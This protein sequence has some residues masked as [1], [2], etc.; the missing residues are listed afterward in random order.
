VKVEIKL[1]AGLAQR[2]GKREMVLELQAG[3]TVADAEREL[4]S[5]IKGWPGNVAWA[6]NE[7]YSGAQQTL[8]EG[9]VLAAIP[10]VSGG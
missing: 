5:R 7:N 1:F 3:A 10:A 9:D 2:A 6:V 8:R 4:A